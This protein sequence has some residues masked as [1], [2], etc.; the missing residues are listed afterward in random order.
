M[1][2]LAFTMTAQ[3]ILITDLKTRVTSARSAAVALNASKNTNINKLKGK[4]TNINKLK[5]KNTKLYKGRFIIEL[6]NNM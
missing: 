5:G 3:Y 2:I 6:A 4:N 1:K